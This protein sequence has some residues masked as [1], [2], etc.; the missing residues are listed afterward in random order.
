MDWLRSGQPSPRLG[1]QPDLP[2]GEVYLELA[3]V[4]DEAE[5]AQSPFG[6]WLAGAQPRFAQPLGR[7]VR[8]DELDT[9]AP[10]SA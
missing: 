10:G 5:A 1:T 2:L 6:R 9:V 3:A 7:A 4:V 8:T